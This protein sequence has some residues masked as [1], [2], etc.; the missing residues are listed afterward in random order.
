MK[1]KAGFYRPQVKM[2][3]IIMNP[4]IS[5]DKKHPTNLSKFVL[6][7]IWELHSNVNERK[8]DDSS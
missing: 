5:Q 6:N 4:E 7:F 3:L 2:G 1:R 8:N